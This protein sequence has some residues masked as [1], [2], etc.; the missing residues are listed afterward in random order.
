[1]LKQNKVQNVL[2]INPSSVLFEKC[3]STFSKSYIWLDLHTQKFFWRLDLFAT[4]FLLFFLF[5][6]NADLRHEVFG[7]LLEYLQNPDSHATVSVNT[8]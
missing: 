3:G 8:A 4:L 5:I 2:E 7:V 6:E 1:M